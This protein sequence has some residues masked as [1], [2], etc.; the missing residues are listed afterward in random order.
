[1]VNLSANQATV[2]NRPT[3]TIFRG[4]LEP[5]TTRYDVGADGNDLPGTDNDTTRFALAIDV[6]RGPIGIKSLTSFVKNSANFLQDNDFIGTLPNE[7]VRFAFQQTDKITD[8]E[9]FSQEIRLQSNHSGPWS[10]TIGGL[11]WTERVDLSEQNN[12]ASPLAP[13]TKADVDAYFAIADA[14]P[15]RDFGRD[16]DHASLFAFAEYAFTDALK[17]SAEGRYVVE[18]IKYSLSQPNYVFFDTI[19]PGPAPGQPIIG[20][21]NIVNTVDQAKITEKYFVPRVAISYQQNPDINLYASV[22]TGVKPGGYNTSGVIL[23]DD[24]AIYKRESLIAY[25]V[26]AKTSWLNDR[27]M[28]NVAGFYQ[29]YSD[30]QVRSQ[31]FN[32]QTQLLQGVTENAGVTRILG[33]ELES[34][35]RP[36]DNLTL[37]ANYTFLDAEFTKFTV[38]SNG[39]SRIAELPDCVVIRLPL[40]RLTCELN[41]S[42]LTPPDIPQHRVAFRGEY[43]ASLSDTLDLFVDGIVTYRSKSFGDTSNVLVQRGRTVVDLGVGLKTKKLRAE[44]FAEN[45]F[46]DR[47]VSDGALYINF[48]AGFGPAAFGYLSD[49][50]KIG[51]RLSASF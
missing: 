43:V 15:R 18:D 6:D 46:D 25:E 41:R 8:T 42:G 30:Q 17:I 50:R 38:L 5:A 44:I 3:V 31:I 34:M 22:G 26:G 2:L 48:A 19:R 12:T 47:T 7:P 45:L 10:W 39:S 36:V 51:L 16:T 29:D 27:V 4:T 24:T 32:A 13:V 49:P 35:L 33:F 14:R 23:F 11:Y 21:L 20:T 28:F 9:Q 40:N 1:V 37:T